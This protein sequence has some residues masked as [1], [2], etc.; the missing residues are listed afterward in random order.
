MLRCGRAPGRRRRGIRV[1]VHGLLGAQQGG[2][3]SAPAGLVR[4]IDRPTMIDIQSKQT[5]ILVS[6]SSASRAVPA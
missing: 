6:D 3:A 1:A 5:D 4:A 2:I